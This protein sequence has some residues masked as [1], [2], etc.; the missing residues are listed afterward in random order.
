MMKRA[1]LEPVLIVSEG[2][3]PPADTV[4]A[5]V[6]TEYLYPVAYQDPPVVDEQFEQDVNL[7]EQ[8]LS[9]I[10]PDGSIVISH[11]LIFLPDYTKHHIAA[12]RLA[13]ARPGISW[14]H[15]V[16]S[17]TNPHTLIQE[18]EMYAGPYKELLMSS[19]PNA[20]I[21]YPNAYDIPRVAVNFQYEEDHIVEIP[22]ST[23]PIEGM[24]P[25]VQRLYNQKLLGDAE[26]LMIY[27]LRLDRGKY[28]EAAVY[29][30]AACKRMG[31]ADP[32]LIFCDFQS[33]GGDK[34][35]YRQELKQLAYNQQAAEC[36]TFLSEFDDM[37][38]ME[39][40]HDV[41]LDLFTLSNIFCMPSK[42][43]TYSLITQ[44]AMLKGN[45]CL[46]NQDFAPFRQIFG[47]NALYK[48]F[49]GANI[50]ISGYNGEIHTTHGEVELYYNDVANAVKYY[51]ENDKVLAA[52][53]WVRTQRN[54][55]KVF[56][57]YI[58][59]L[60]ASRSAQV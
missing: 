47:K 13:E 1:G 60:I 48:Q 17:A 20:V 59:P 35:T 39:V 11:D 16:H 6:Q 19:F 15:W 33:T 44:E 31:L 46:I 28:A 53:T 49:D 29:I 2:W 21:C 45:L 55:D 43:E 12:R 22:H 7:I 14:L 41:I 54:P 9:D 5:D 26:V 4:F 30:I 23:D 24:H 58:L 36:V 52:K 40:S 50:A 57:D 34:V 56:R 8:Q 18:R 38:Q 27:P 3:E 25:L 42:S 32:R 51:L 37:A 10:I